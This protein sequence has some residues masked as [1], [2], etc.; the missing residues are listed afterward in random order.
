MTSISKGNTKRTIRQVLEL[1]HYVDGDFADSPGTICLVL[2]D[3]SCLSVS[4]CADGWRVKTAES[5]PLPVNMGPA[6]E[7][8]LRDMSNSEI[9]R[10]V[11][12]KSIER[13]DSLVAGPSDAQIGCLFRVSD[14]LDLVVLVLD[15]ELRLLREN[16]LEELPIQDY[17]IIDEE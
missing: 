1:V 12:N 11:R 15:D 3:G 13:V 10:S 9:A 17:R 2:D 7:M 5:M 14:D 4:G 6:G 16:Q 8:V